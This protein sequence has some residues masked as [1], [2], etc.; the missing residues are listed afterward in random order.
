[1]PSHGVTLKQYRKAVGKDQVVTAA[2]VAGKR[3]KREGWGDPM[4]ILGVPQDQ[5]GLRRLAT[6]LKMKVFI[7]PAIYDLEK[8]RY[9]LGAWP[10]I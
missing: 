6:L 2:E 7:E 3:R 5:K 9:C 8:C 10:K 4:V 1:M